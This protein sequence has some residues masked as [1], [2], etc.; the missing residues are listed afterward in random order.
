MSQPSIRPRPQQ[1]DERIHRDDVEAMLAV[2]QEKGR[3]IEPALVD[4]MA[5]QVEAIVQ[6][7]Y[8]AEMAARARQVPKSDGRGA[9]VGLAIT[10]LIFAI[11]LSA[12]AGDIA[13]FFGLAIAWV[14]IVLVNVAL[15]M[16]RPSED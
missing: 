2:R 8:Q 12:I 9:Q 16:R 3:G 13:G 14:G 11:P 10:S 4:S 1:P 5:A 6:R 15:A 7:R